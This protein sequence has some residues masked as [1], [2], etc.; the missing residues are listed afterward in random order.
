MKILCFNARSINGKQCELDNYIYLHNPDVICITETWLKS[1]IVVT[2]IKDYNVYRCDR[3][4]KNGGGVLVAVKNCIISRLKT[5][6]K[7]GNCECIIVDI[8]RE[9]NVLCRISCIYRPPNAS[10]NDTKILCQKLESEMLVDSFVLTGDLNLDVDWEL[11]TANCALARDFILFCHKIGASQ[12]VKEP[13]R[14][15]KILDIVL[16]PNIEIDRVAIEIVEP[17]STSD[18]AGVLVNID[19][20]LKS[21]HKKHA[22]RNFRKA[23]YKLINSYLMTLDWIKIF[24]NCNSLENQWQAFKCVIEMLVQSFVPIAVKATHKQP[25]FKS[26]LRRLQRVKQKHYRN[27]CNNRNDLTEIRYKNFAEYYKSQ[28]LASK[29]QYEEKLFSDSKDTKLFYG[30]VKTNSKRETG[31]PPLKRNNVIITDDK[32]KCN[33]FSEEF[34]SYFTMDD[35]NIPFYETNVM[36]KLSSFRCDT[37]DIIKS[38]R[39]MQSKTTLDPQGFCLYFVKRII[40]NIAKPL[41]IIFNASLNEG[42]IPDDW[43]IAHIVPLFK[44]ADPEL[45]NNYRSISLTSIFSKILESVIRPQML[46]HL[47]MNN[48]LPNSQHGFLP[49]RSIV[50]NLVKCVDDWSSNLDEGIQTDVIYLDF[51]KC[52]NSVSH[53]KLLFKL[54]KLGFED[55][56]HKWFSN[57]LLDRIQLVRIS[58][59]LSSAKC[60]LSGTPEGT[61][62]GPVLYICYSLDMFKCVDSSVISGYADDTKLYKTINCE[63]DHVSLQNDLNNVIAWTKIWQLSLNVVKTKVLTIGKKKCAK[64]Y[65]VNSVS[66]EYVDNIVDLGVKI[67]SN[68]SFTYHCNSV[69]KR[70]HY[71]IRHM[72]TTFKNH[73]N[74]FYLKIFKLYIRP[75]LESSSQIWSP[76]FKFNIDRIEKV[77][78]YFTRRLS[79]MNEK[80]YL[81]RLHSLNID[82]L[83]HRRICAD[84]ILLFKIVNKQADFES[85]SVIYKH[86]FRGNVKNL[87]LIP[88]K[89]ERRR[90]VFF[91]RTIENWNNLSNDI[92]GSKIGEFKR[93]IA[94]LKFNYKGSAYQ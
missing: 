63:L 78:R 39:K 31:I 61:V 47:K 90:S 43:K 62:I 34:A 93:K 9:N 38:V 17:F 45:C 30:Y 79:Q 33:L 74:E 28:Y 24:E 87:K 55:K 84:L 82:T 57:F 76:C 73:N 70:A 7:V 75:I 4:S 69:I 16:V 12:C 2:A 71:A 68:L 1:D 72:F 85:P 81:D 51:S 44:K 5:A 46:N 89:S 58:D 15:K 27:Y 19:Y 67:H 66:I 80:S 54:L 83:E 77:Q 18:H 50:T 49:G 37:L 65:D 40:A 35:A 91:L 42:N 60:V 86:S 64:L 21:C 8:T 29:V 41:H 48:L 6:I 14:G 20:V 22:K 32:S 88:F 23:D 36:N 10:I 13:T 94:K 53:Q 25:W 11:M 92:V 59:K 3:T 26:R 56:C 52:F